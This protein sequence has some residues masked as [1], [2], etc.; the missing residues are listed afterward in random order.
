[1]TRCR[2]KLYQKYADEPLLDG[3]PEIAIDSKG[4]PSKG[5]KNDLKGKDNDD[6]ND[7]DPVP[8]NSF[9]DISLN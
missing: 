2:S 9:K 5:D 3:K 6:D 1:M 4:E 8:T 7:E